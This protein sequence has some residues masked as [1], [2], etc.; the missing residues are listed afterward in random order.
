MR[1]CNKYSLPSNEQSIAISN[2]AL[3]SQD[4]CSSGAY[5][6]QCIDDRDEASFTVKNYKNS[7]VFLS[8]IF[9]AYIIVS[10]GFFHASTVI[11]TEASFEGLLWQ[12]RS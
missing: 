3:V 7:G 10:K 9:T 2:A 4:L 8:W 12:K 5:F 6:P 11:Y 1:V